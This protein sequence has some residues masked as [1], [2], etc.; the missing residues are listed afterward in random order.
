MK[1]IFSY[2]MEWV[3]A[4][5][6][7]VEPAGADKYD[8]PCSDKLFLEI[9]RTLSPLALSVL[10]ISSASACQWSGTQGKIQRDGA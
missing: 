7:R 8:I 4:C 2:S 3:P 6:N 10:T 5:S 1:I 9:W